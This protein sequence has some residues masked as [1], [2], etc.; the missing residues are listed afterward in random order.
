MY[1]KIIKQRYGVECSC[2][3]YKPYSEILSESKSKGVMMARLLKN[4]A[5]YHCYQIKRYGT[6]DKEI[7]K[8][9]KVAEAVERLA[10]RN[11]R[12]QQ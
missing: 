6:T 5:C 7:I 11:K 8:E 3:D 10:A 1:D 12:K 2:G 9:K 4:E